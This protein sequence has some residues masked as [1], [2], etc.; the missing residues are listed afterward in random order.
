MAPSP[1]PS[2]TVESIGGREEGREEKEEK[3]E[4]GKSQIAPM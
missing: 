3:E 2:P 4:E 1:P